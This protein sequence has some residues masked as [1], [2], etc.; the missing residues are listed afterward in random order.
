MT[1]S[2][3]EVVIKI[4]FDLIDDQEPTAQQLA[5]KYA[6]MAKQYRSIGAHAAEVVSVEKVM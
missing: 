5:E 4:E 3:Y 2:R 1:I 6:D